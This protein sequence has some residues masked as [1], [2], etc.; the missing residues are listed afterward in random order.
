MGGVSET[1]L[2][3][4]SGRVNRLLRPLRTKC[5]TLAACHNTRSQAPSVV[6]TYSHAKPMSYASTPPL[7]ILDSDTRLPLNGQH[8]QYTIDLARRTHAVCEAFKVVV[9]KTQ[10]LRKDPSSNDVPSLTSMCSIVA[11]SHIEPE[12]DASMTVTEQEEQSLEILNSLYDSVP[13]PYRGWTLVSHALQLILD[14]C[15]HNATLLDMLLDIT[16]DQGLTYRSNTILRSLLLLALT[17]PSLSHPPAICHPD[18]S[19]FF[20]RLLANWDKRGLH[21]SAFCGIFD[22]VMQQ[23]QSINAWSCKATTKLLYYNRKKKPHC[24]VLIGC[25]LIRFLQSLGSGEACNNQNQSNGLVSHPCRTTALQRTLHDWVTSVLSHQLRAWKLMDGKWN[26]LEDSAMMLLETCHECGAHKVQVGTYVPNRILSH[27]FI[28]LA[29]LLLSYS[30]NYCHRKH[31]LELLRGTE[32]ETLTYEPLVSQTFLVGTG[33]EDF[34]ESV[35]RYAAALKKH[36]LPRLEASLWACAL[37]EVER[38]ETLIWERELQDGVKRFRDE[39]MECVEDS[40][41]CFA[42]LANS[43]GYEWEWEPTVECWI[44]KKPEDTSSHERGRE[45]RKVYQGD[46][47]ASLDCER[48]KKARLGRR[49]SSAFTS[50]L[51]NALLNR[52]KVHDSANTFDS[53]DGDEVELEDF[54]RHFSDTLNPSSDDGLDLFAY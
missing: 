53:E 41:R 18:H 15:P 16:T 1:R 51:S 48:R 8:P 29:T 44:R 39:L 24:V 31:L 11:G 36:G 14:T 7:M 47:D 12:V 50:I 23:V 32:P 2:D 27:D 49:S 46:S 9:E 45:K 25:S 4:T 6:M 54:Y 28:S 17:P 22:S 42:E 19:D 30:Q 37:R 52:Q 38:I 3:L 26:D 34:K 20:V 35:R 21:V 40:E 10:H 43:G 33:I 13:L 5:A